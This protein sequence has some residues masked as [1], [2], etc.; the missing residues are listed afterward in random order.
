MAVTVV[1][2]LIVSVQVAPL[3]LVHPLQEA[4]GFPP[5]VDGAVR[6]TE[7]PE[8]YVNVKLVVP[9]PAL[10]VSLGDA[11]MVTPVEGLAE[12]TVRT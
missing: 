4:N 8:S 5:A 2:A 11:V 12:S 9:L 10:L 6:V 3:V 1:L 7:V